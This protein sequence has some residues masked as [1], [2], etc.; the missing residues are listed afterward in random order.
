MSLT[1]SESALVRQEESESFLASLVDAHYASADY[2]LPILKWRQLRVLFEEAG[3]RPHQLDPGIEPF[4]RCIFAFGALVSD[5]PCLVGADAPRFSE[6][7]HCRGIDLS[8]YAHRRKQIANQL[9]DQ[10][11]SVIDARGIW[12]DSSSQAISVMTVSLTIILAWF[13]L[14]Y[15]FSLYV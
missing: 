10:A 7:G 9:L 6:L 14:S 15:S 3:R 13:E 4:V 2:A 5:S 12:K 1:S 11:V 8:M